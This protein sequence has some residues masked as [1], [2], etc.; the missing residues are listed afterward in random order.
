LESRVV[1]VD[2]KGKI[3]QR[4][5]IEAEGKRII[6]VVVGGKM[7]ES[8]RIRMDGARIDDPEALQLSRTAYNEISKRAAAILR[9]EARR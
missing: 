1:S 5:V 7:R 6:F 4:V 8:G 3:A 2:R 9:P